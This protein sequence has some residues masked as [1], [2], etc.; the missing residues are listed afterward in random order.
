[1]LEIL[2]GLLCCL[3][4]FIYLHTRSFAEI[5]CLNC[6]LSHKYNKKSKYNN[7]SKYNNKSVSKY[8]LT[9]NIVCK[10]DLG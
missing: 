7:I 9:M 2:I 4:G 6:K 1:M 3:L 8:L 5:T 10:Q